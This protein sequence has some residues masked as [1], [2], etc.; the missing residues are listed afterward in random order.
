M[1]SRVRGKYLLASPWTFHG[2][3]KYGMFSYNFGDIKSDFQN[4]F[5]KTKTFLQTN[6]PWRWRIIWDSLDCTIPNCCHVWGHVIDFAEGHW[7][8]VRKNGFPIYYNCQFISWR[9]H[10][11]N[12]CNKFI[13]IRCLMWLQL[14]IG[15]DF[16][17]QSFLKNTLQ[18]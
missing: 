7:G 6:L 14:V 2:V 18:W 12:V 9:F 17:L 8:M 11:G 1:L 15:H 16:K 3:T 4:H 13:K 10:I 5:Y